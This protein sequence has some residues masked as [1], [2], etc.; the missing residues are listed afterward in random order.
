MSE[1][2]GVYPLEALV[3]ECQTPESGITG[4]A[5][6]QSHESSLRYTGK[7]RSMSGRTSSSGVYLRKKRRPG[8][9]IFRGLSPEYGSVRPN[10]LRARCPRRKSER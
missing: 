9:A 2:G 3:L 5:G 4:S 10:V 8:A 6:S 7:K 1:P